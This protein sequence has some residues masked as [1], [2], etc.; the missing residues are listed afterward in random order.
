MPEG[1]GPSDRVY[2]RSLRILKAEGAHTWAPRGPSMQGRKRHGTDLPL[3][4]GFHPQNVDPQRAPRHIQHGRENPNRSAIS[5]IPP[6]ALQ[7]AGHRL[8]PDTAKPVQNQ[9]A[10]PVI[11]GSPLDRK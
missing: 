11:S 6:L 5:E 7:A 8:L 2:D 3:L 10:V 1:G 4:R 9:S